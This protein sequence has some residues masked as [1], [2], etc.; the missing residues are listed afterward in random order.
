MKR[1]YNLCFCEQQHCFFQ[2]KTKRSLMSSIDFK[3]NN[4]KTSYCS[5]ATEISIRALTEWQTLYIISCRLGWGLILLAKE[6]LLFSPQAFAPAL[7]D[8]TLIQGKTKR[9]RRI[10]EGYLQT[11][12]RKKIRQCLIIMQISLLT[13]PQWKIGKESAWAQNPCGGF[14]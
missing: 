3:T 7:V 10:A 8:S 6:T 12:L 14:D 11:F 1:P 2:Q 13:I 5:K 4:C 9:M